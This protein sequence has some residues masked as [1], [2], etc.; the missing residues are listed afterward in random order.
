MLEVVFVCCALGQPGAPGFHDFGNDRG[1][2]GAVASEIHPEPLLELRSWDSGGRL[3]A[4][5]QMDDLQ[6]PSGSAA[7]TEGS[8]DVGIFAHYFIWDDIDVLGT[9]VGPDNGLGFGVRGSYFL[10]SNTEIELAVGRISTD[11]SGFGMTADATGTALWAL[12][13]YNFDSDSKLVP[14]VHAGPGFWKAEI[15]GTGVDDSGLALAAGGGAR[16][17]LSDSWSLRADAQVLQTF[18]D[19]SL[20]NFMVLFGVGYGWH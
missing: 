16:Y 15:D 13:R 8:I 17:Y 6:E 9:S 5:N 11:V 19:D 14:Y 1:A 12:Y 7:R 4:T 18:S 10:D 3:L 2:S 20:T